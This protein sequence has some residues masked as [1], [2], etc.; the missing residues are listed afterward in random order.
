MRCGVLLI[1]R[2]LTWFIVAYR[3]W[4]SGRGPLRDVRCSFALEE[5]C[6]AYGLRIARTASGAREAIG[7][8]R[9]RL[10]RCRDACLLRDGRRLAWAPVHDRAPGELIAQIRADAEHDAAIARL[11]VT[12]RSVARLCGDAAA[13]QACAGAAAGKPRVVCRPSAMRRWRRRVVT[14]AYLALAPFVALRDLWP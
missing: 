12:R 5:S 4:L 7:R 3:R 2:V 1:L 11:L 8:I 9:R 14:L 10:R 13:V 6:S